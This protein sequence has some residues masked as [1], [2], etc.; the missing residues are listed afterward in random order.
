[1]RIDYIRAAIALT[2]IIG[3][4]PVMGQ[5]E[6]QIINIP[7]SNPGEPLTLEIGILSADIEVIFRTASSSR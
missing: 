6:P 4:A 1:M 5:T 2:F 3:S 7:L